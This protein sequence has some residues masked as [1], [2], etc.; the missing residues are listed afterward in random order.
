MVAAWEVT[1]EAAQRLDAILALNFLA[2]QVGA[3]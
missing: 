1:L 3:G 2:L